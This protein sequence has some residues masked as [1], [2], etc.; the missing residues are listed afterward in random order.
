MAKAMLID[1]TK[2]TACRACQVACKQWNQLPAEKTTCQGTYENPPELSPKT[3][4]KL[5]FKEISENGEVKWLFRKMQC[6]HC[7][8]ATCV[9]VCPTGAAHETELGA[10]VIDQDKC[11][12]CKYCVQNCPFE[13]PQ[14]DTDTNTV[15]KCRMCYDRVSNGLTPACAQTCPPGAIQFGEREE[16]VSLGLE[17][18]SALKA[19]GNLDARLYGETELGGLGVM[20]VLAEKAKT[21]DLPEE[22]KVPISAVL[23]QDI[24]K[25]LGPILGGAAVAAF[26]LSFLL[27]I[28]YKPGEEAEEGGEE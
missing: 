26:A 15:K 14:Y 27:N 11:T 28:G 2:C 17:R 21:Y 9:K 20:Y 4:T 1:V 6:M 25:P 16:M 22:P 8:D 5:K 19:D 24:L 23:W 18:V 7:T 10:V 3:W 12:G 13:I